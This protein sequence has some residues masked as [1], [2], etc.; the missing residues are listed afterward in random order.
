MVD[1]TQSDG[2]VTDAQGRRQYANRDDAQLVK[3]TEIDATDHNEVRNEMVHLVAQAGITPSNDDLTQIYQ[4]VQILIGRRIE[5][6]TAS[7]NW[8]PPAG[9]YWI[10]AEYW[11]GGGSGGLGVNGGAGSG[12]NGG[13]HVKVILPVIPG[14]PIWIGVG[15]GGAPSTVAGTEGSAGGDSTVAGIAARGGSAGGEGNG[16]AGAS[17]GNPPAIDVANG[18]ALAGAGGSNAVQFD[19]GGHLIYQAGMGGASPSGGGTAFSGIAGTAGSASGSEGSYPGGGGGG[20]INA[21]GG[22]GAAGLVV[23]RY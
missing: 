8:I 13:Q 2:F 4:A 1:F 18:F 9:V 23:V 20:G 16:T 17:V 19:L 5:K 10:S 22:Y 3:G 7:Q 15:A 14:E 6:I 21:P 11:G 12:G